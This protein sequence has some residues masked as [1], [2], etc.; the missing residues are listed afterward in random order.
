MLKTLS[1]CIALIST[2]LFASAD[3]NNSTPKNYI[4]IADKTERV[5]QLF[6]D[7][8]TI[9][10][11]LGYFKNRTNDGQNVDLDLEHE[12]IDSMNDIHQFFANNDAGDPEFFET[13]RTIRD[14]LTEQEVEGILKQAGMF[15]E[16][17]DPISGVTQKRIE[18]ALGYA[19]H[20]HGENKMWR[21]HLAAVL[22]FELEVIRYLQ[23]LMNT[24]SSMGVRTFISSENKI[25]LRPLSNALQHAAEYDDEL[26]K[27][28]LTVEDEEK[29]I[30]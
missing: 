28:L 5:T 2:T 22:A 27:R 9:N 14:S 15:E 21:A 29:Y 4:S 6:R 11:R 7:L 19:D 25:T 26:R 24:L 16:I 13:F 8:K 20:N 1:L 30:V 10:D 17:D 18:R 23:H 3:Q 12:V